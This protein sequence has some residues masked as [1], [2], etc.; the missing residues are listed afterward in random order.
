MSHDDLTQP[1]PV[2]ERP[3][4]D[5]AQ[6]AAAPP[7]SMPPHHHAPH[8]PAGPVRE[9]MVV[10]LPAIVTMT[11]YTLMQFAD[12]MIVARWVNADALAAVGNAGVCAFVPGATMMG[13]ISVVNTFVSQNLGA[14][15]AERGPAYAWNGLWLTTMLWALLLVPWAI[16]LPEIFAG[17]RHLM[18][19]EAVSTNVQAMEIAY[20]RIMVLGLIFTIAARNMSHYF[21]GMHKPAVVMVSAIGAN[22]V[23]IVASLALVMDKVTIPWLADQPI[24]LPALGVS[25]AAWGT[26]IGSAFELLLPIALFLSPRYNTPYRTRAAW[27]PSL[28]HMKDLFKLGWSPAL[29]FGNELIC[30]WIFMAGFI[31][32]FDNGEHAVHNTAGW[33]VLRYMHLSFM[34]AVGCSIALS[35]IV[36]R[37][38]GKQDIPTAVRRTWLGL[39][40]TIAY[41]G[42]WAIAFVMF[43]E[44][45]IA[46]FVTHTDSASTPPDVQ[47]QI[48]KVGAQ[49]L[50]I[51]AAFQMFDAVAIAISGAL[52]GAG[53]TVF[54][55]IVTII[56]SW[57]CIVGLGHVAVHQFPQWGSLGPWGAAALYIILLAITLF[58]RFMGDAWKTKSVVRE[59]EAKAMGIDCRHCGYDLTGLNPAT[60]CPECGG[61]PA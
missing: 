40:L 39:W 14:G 54:P 12:M 28:T 36:G 37:Y 13:L 60:P 57:T 23:N 26:V 48:I 50:I 7:G 2:A 8:P 29:M 53:D 49:V 20:G 4:A 18:H 34:P 27:R 58:W 38:I 42:L 46:V 5:A 35:A 33:I 11:S 32:T 41:M 15:R 25:G 3:R 51:A 30:W 6:G 31:A 17:M 19:L 24:Q 21:Y 47:Q 61:E 1:A 16:F 56:L 52:R 45:L 44:P 9:L 59:R 22:I 43:R 55:G 10:A